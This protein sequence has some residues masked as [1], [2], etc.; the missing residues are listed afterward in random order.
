MRIWKFLPVWF[1]VPDLARVLRDRAI[2][3][4]FPRRRYVVDSHLYPFALILKH[5]KMHASLTYAVYV[6][7]AVERNVS[8]FK[9]EKETDRIK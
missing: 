3:R 7:S 2:R 8:I 4:E 6:F 1:D 9:K 5:V